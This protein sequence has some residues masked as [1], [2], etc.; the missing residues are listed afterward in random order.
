VSQR[1]LFIV[2]LRNEIGVCMAAPKPVSVGQVLE[3]TIISQNGQGE[4]IAKIDNF[5][6]FIKGAEKEKTYKVKINDV[7]RTYAVGE[8]V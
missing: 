7:K 2:F 1:R 4:G 3:V 8:K 6:I 5:V